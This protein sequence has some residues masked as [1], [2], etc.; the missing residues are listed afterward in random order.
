MTENFLTFQI[1]RVNKIK[2][3]QEVY[4]NPGQF[5][6]DKPYNKMCTGKSCFQKNY[7]NEPDIC[8]IIFCNWFLLCLILPIQ[9]SKRKIDD[10]VKIKLQNKINQLRQRCENRKFKLYVVANSQFSIIKVATFTISTAWG[11]NIFQFFFEKCRGGPRVFH[12]IG[13]VFG[14]E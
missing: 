7:S 1:D 3:I 12:A 2:Q 10:S 13:F 14:F 11:F 6:S 4:C 5:N 9:I 8:S